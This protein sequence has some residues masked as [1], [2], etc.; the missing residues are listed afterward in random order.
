MEEICEIYKPI[1][2][3]QKTEPVIWSGNQKVSG[4]VEIDTPLIINPGTT[5]ELDAGASLILRNRL[6]ALGGWPSVSPPAMGHDAER[7]HP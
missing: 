3:T 6:M 1:I 4:V 7:H 5:I 2:A